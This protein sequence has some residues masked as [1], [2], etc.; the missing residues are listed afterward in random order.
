[1]SVFGLC[2]SYIKDGVGHLW[3]RDSDTRLVMLGQWRWAK[4]GTMWVL[5]GRGKG[6]EEPKE[7][8][9]TRPCYPEMQPRETV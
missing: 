5:S 7:G 9:E 4:P 3:G 6:A 1:M 2:L 8:G